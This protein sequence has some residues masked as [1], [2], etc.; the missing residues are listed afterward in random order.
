MRRK[1]ILLMTLL[2]FL[3]TIRRAS[4]QTSQQQPQSAVYDAVTLLNV[5]HGLNALVV[6]VAPNYLLVDPLT[7]NTQ[8]VLKGNPIPPTFLAN[9]DKGH[10]ILMAILKRNAGLATDATDAQVTAAYAN[11]PFLGGITAHALVA[12]NVFSTVGT[13]SIPPA[14]SGGAGANILGNVVNGTADFLIKRAEDELAV[15]VFSKLQAFMAKYPEFNILFPQ[16]CALIAKVESYDFSN[17]LSALEGAIQSDL[18]GFVGR[19]SGLYQL[20][21]Y[22]TLNKKFSPLTLIFSASTIINDIGDKKNMPATLADLGTQPYL[23]EQNNYASAV[24]LICLLS[25]CMRDLYIGQVKP[26][27]ANY[28]SIQ[29]IQSMIPSSL[30]DRQEFAVYFLGLMYQ[31]LGNINFSVGTTQRTVQQLVRGWLGN[32]DRLVTALATISTEMKTADSLLAVIKNNDQV[33]PGASKTAQRYTLYTQVAG[34]AIKLAT[35]IIEGIDQNSPVARITVELQS[36]WSPLTSDAVNIVDAFDQ[37]QYS[38]AI[39]DLGNLLGTLSKF[40]DAVKSDKTQTQAVTTSVNDGLSSRVNALSNTANLVKITLDSL[41][42]LG[43]G[44]TDEVTLNLNASIQL[45]TDSLNGLTKAQAGLQ[46]QQ[47]NLSN[48]V[49]NLSTI[50][51]YAGVLASISQAQNSAEVE[52]LLESTA[53]PSGSSRIKKVTA[54]NI[55]V[56]AYVGGFS[57]S[58][59]TGLGFTNRYGLTAPIGFTFSNG[60][61]AAGSISLFAGVFDIGS[62]VQ[63]KLNNQGAYEQNISLAGII[64]PSIHLAYG[65]PW[66]LPITFGA[67]WQWVSPTTNATNNIQLSSHFNLFLGVDIPLFNLVAAKKR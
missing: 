17:S 55:A 65:F 67:G 59:M 39:Q 53:L 49:F 37:K 58:G 33:N 5:L 66:Y 1:F 44:A 30:A 43:A 11:N 62:V 45:L 23:Q 35:P 3:A 25:N 4:A 27:Q 38:L 61:G 29:Q 52:N 13:P 42:R 10:L 54:F 9:N 63:Y 24:S 31:Q 18:R 15:A 7:G 14:A 48:S 46:L 21:K 40:L 51:K 36:Y 28:V 20:P 2:L 6:P 26:Q 8:S 16:T 19:I 47:K 64:S 56:N 50:L 60:W 41:K 32:E 57:R 12:D 34:Y 22:Q